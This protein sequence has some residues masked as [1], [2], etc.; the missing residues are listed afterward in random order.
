MAAGDT[1]A[2]DSLPAF[3]GQDPWRRVLN[4]L[5]DALLGAAGSDFGQ[6]NFRGAINYL[7]EGLELDADSHKLASER[8]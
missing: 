8:A 1:A 3:A 7:K 5:I 6:G 2:Q 4:F